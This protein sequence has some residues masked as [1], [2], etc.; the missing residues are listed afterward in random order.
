V[1]SE[2]EPERD[3]GGRKHAAHERR[4]HE[5]R[6]GQHAARRRYRRLLA[7]LPGEFRRRFGAE[8][9]DT[10]VAHLSGA[11]G[12]ASRLR[13]WAAA[14]ADLVGAAARQR[15]NG[16]PGRGRGAGNVITEG[17]GMG[18]LIQDVRYAVRGLFRHPLT[19]AAAG[20]TLALGIGAAT[21]IFSVVD[22]LMLRPLPYPEPDRLV[23]VW[24]EKPDQGWYETDVNPADAWDWRERAGVFDDLAVYVD[25]PMAL[26]GADRPDLLGGIETT[27]NLFSVLGV[28][29]AAG[30]AFTPGD[31]AEGAPGTAVLAHGFWQR[32]FGGDPEVLGRE[33]LLDER[34]HTV[35]GILPADFA[36]LD[37]SPDVFTASRGDPTEA[38]RGAHDHEAIARLLPGVSAAAANQAV[39]DVARALQRE[40]ADTNEGWLASIETVRRFLLGDIAL[41]ASLVLAAAVGLL[42]LMA[43]VNVANLL[44]ARA[45]ARQTE[46]AV[47]GALGAGRGVLVRQL[48]AESAVLAAVGGLA[49]VVLAEWGR[50]V[51]VAGLPENVPPVFEFA[52]DVR[53]LGFALGVTAGSVLTFG[54]V[55]ALRTARPAATLRTG[56][57]SRGSGRLAGALVVVQTAL[58]LLLLVAGSVLTRSLVALRSQD[59]GWRAERV[60]YLRVTPSETRY[61]AGAELDA[62]YRE[63]EER[64]ASVPGVEG[65]GAIQS[66]PL[67]GSNWGTT[68]RVAGTDEERPARVGYVSDGYF[69]A[70][71]IALLAGRTVGS[72]DG[73]DE[74]QVAVVN[75]RFAQLYLPGV[76]P[77]G[78]SVIDASGAV[79]VVGLVRDH[80]ERGVNRA[81]EP[82]LYRSLTQHPIRTRTLAV[83]AE[84]DPSALIEVLRQA[85][86]SVDGDLPVWDVRTLADVVEMRVGGFS[87]I[88][89]LM[90]GFAM[91]SLVLG[92]VGIYGVTAH[93]VGQRRH[94]I[95][96]RMALGADRA[97]VQR[98]VVRQSLTRAGLG[99]AVGIA[100]AIPLAG[101]LSGIAPGVDPRDP[102][103]LGGALAVLAAV[104]LLASWLPARRAS[105]VDPVRALSAE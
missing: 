37:E 71:G 85:V 45:G 105:G 77:V 12:R 50:R 79:Q 83:R 23:V 8:M 100:L 43:C 95:G 16:D 15:W 55:P 65:V 22:G 99:L 2:P 97:G 56:P 59:F 31:A 74:A 82:A 66:A 98:M 86:W 49:G 72:R 39:R 64:L 28:D 32:R 51:I 4:E 19:A 40:H 63:L 81:P 6:T 104:A 88:A 68:V 7:L 30:R 3:R 41:Q 62:L 47:R 93:G 70:M 24:A 92:A 1:S 60:V 52:L 21:A 38:A 61:P 103:L 25:R 69:D 80:V 84:G 96:V 13:V 18:S 76:E 78:A 75:E 44:L 67:Q 58:A 27:P 20:V 102:R 17:G 33:L 54:L 9:E 87:L 29:V 46:M 101:A 57:R 53:V 10:F 73:P 26:S 89:R 36:F 34:P 11:R 48:L 42:L 90:G 94:E 14:L 35:I 5:G 91:L